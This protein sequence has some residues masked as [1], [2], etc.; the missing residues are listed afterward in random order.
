MPI[1]VNSRLSCCLETITPE[2]NLTTVI[3]VAQTNNT[4]GISFTY[5]R[6]PLFIIV[7]RSNLERVLLE[8][9]DSSECIKLQLFSSCNSEDNTHVCCPLNYS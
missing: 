5:I 6:G 3:Y 4:R 1:N 8:M 9:Q 7:V 2:A